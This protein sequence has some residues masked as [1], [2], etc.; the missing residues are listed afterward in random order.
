MKYRI[1]MT[2][3]LGVFLIPIGLQA[4]MRAAD[5]IVVKSCDGDVRISDMRIELRDYVLTVERV[6]EGMIYLRDFEAGVEATLD[7]NSKKCFLLTVIEDGL[8]MKVNCCWERVLVPEHADIWERLTDHDRAF[9]SR[10]AMHRS[11]IAELRAKL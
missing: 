7:L 8:E 11:L 1:L 4:Q 5:D 10:T 3:L 6:V 9:F 2:V